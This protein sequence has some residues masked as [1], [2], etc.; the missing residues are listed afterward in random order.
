MTDISR[1]VSE[2]D[3]QA[4][5]DGRLQPER[6]TVVDAYIAAH[7]EIRERL[8]QYAAQRQ[9]LRDAL[10]EADRSIPGQL[11][12]AR[13]VAERRRRQR[14]HLAGIAAAMGFLALGWIGG[15]AMRGETNPSGLSTPIAVA[16]AITADAII[17]HRT[18]TVDARH[19]VE[20]GAAEEQDLVQWLSQ[21]LGLSLMIPDLGALGFRLIGGRLLP[22]REGAAA[23]LMYDDGT[24]RRLTLYLRVNIA[25]EAK[26]YQ[27]EQ[28]VGAFYWADEGVACAVVAAA[29]RGLLLRAAQ[30]VYEQL[31]PNAPKDEFSPESGKGG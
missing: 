13:L 1:P 22:G 5:L 21:R 3:L 9:E 8:L 16:R 4:R 20:V 7:P 12:I 6:V 18:F 17:A 24:G 27:E 25:T 15:W 14:R 10:A 29:D 23:Q 2:V 19:P 11:Q 30:G 28:G 26:L 31:F